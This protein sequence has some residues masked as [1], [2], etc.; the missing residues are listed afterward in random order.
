MDLPAP[1]RPEAEAHTRQGGA[2]PGPRGP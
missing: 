1:R 2:V